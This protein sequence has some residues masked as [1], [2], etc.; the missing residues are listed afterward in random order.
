MVCPLSCVHYL[1][2]SFLS[3]DPVLATTVQSFYNETNQSDAELPICQS[4]S[5]I[6][7]YISLHSPKYSPL[8]NWF[9][10][11]YII[12]QDDAQQVNVCDRPGVLWSL[13]YREAAIY[14]EEGFNNDKFDC[15]PQSYSKLP[16]YF[17]VHNHCY[18][19]IDLFA[20]LL[21]LALAI[22]EK[23]AV[24]GFHLTESVSDLLL[25]FI[26]VSKLFM[27]HTDSRLG[28]TV[29]SDSYWCNVLDQVLL[30][31]MSIFSK[32]QSKHDQDH[33]AGVDGYRSDCGVVATGHSL[34]GHSITSTGLFDR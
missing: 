5:D 27:Y 30:D 8:F 4:Y 10:K 18:Y 12:P 1:F 7:E 34:S 21:V 25:N 23:P 29:W 14:L 31:G 11:R 28:R 17:A 22:F 33:C 16:A 15:H 2:K 6:D 32:T 26:I 9:T 13:N 19:L 20:C 24:D 3:S